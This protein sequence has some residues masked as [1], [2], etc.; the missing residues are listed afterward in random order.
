MFKIRIVNRG[1]NLTIFNPI[2]GEVII[3]GDGNCNTPLLLDVSLTNRCTYNCPYCY[4]HSSPNG[5]HMSFEDFKL[6]LKKMKEARVFQV[7]Y[8]GGN[9]NEHPDFCKILKATYE[10]GVIPNYSTNGS[11]LTDEI[12]ESSSIYCG[13]VAVSI[14]KSISLY[15]EILSKLISKIK[16]VNLH[17]VMTKSNVE[18]IIDFLS[19]PPDWTID[20]NAVVLL[21]YKRVNSFDDEPSLEEYQR[22]FGEAEKS[23]FK[24]A[25]DACSY[26]LIKM[27]YPKT[28]ESIYDYCQGARSSAYIS[29][30][31]IMSPCSFD[32]FQ[33]ESNDLH[34]FSIEDIFTK[35]NSFK[36]RR[37]EINELK[38]CCQ[39]FKENNF[40]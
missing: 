11:N 28:D 40:K 36:L 6:L 14:H 26:P 33:D 18:N 16:K 5:Q 23:T 15:K 38:I 21:R 25:F 7:A 4:K 1:E 19:S 30:N 35:S 24:I 8:G 31:L 34:I 9:P 39:Y 2:S 27:F 32:I 10:S 20:I 37:K 29:E 3:E 13:S 22:I 17:F 12:I